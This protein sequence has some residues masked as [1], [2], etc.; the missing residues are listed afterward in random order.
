MS[1]AARYN[2]PSPRSL[3]VSPEPTPRRPIPRQ[4]S[5]FEKRLAFRRTD[6]SEYVVA[7]IISTAEYALAETEER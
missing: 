1:H 4:G 7:E 5:S 2:M 6:Q 3:S